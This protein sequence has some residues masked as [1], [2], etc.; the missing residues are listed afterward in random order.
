MDVQQA[1]RLLPR[2]VGVCALAMTAAFVAPSAAMASP[3]TSY[4]PGGTGKTTY[5][6]STN[7]FRIYDTKRDSKAVAVIFYRPSGASVG[8]KSCHEGYRGSCQGDLERWITGRL[9][10]RTG[11]GLGTHPRNYTYGGAKCFNA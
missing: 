1:R 10:M 8:F 3:V 6:T 5:E 11:V 9:C 2:A 4:A 7:H